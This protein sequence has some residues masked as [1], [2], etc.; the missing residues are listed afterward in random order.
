[1]KWSMFGSV[2]SDRGILL[3]S[4]E[5]CIENTL[6]QYVAYVWYNERFVLIL[7]TFPILLTNWTFLEIG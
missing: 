2:I 1:M 3:C 6:I 5:T 4:S 7:Y